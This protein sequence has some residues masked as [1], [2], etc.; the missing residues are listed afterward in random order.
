METITII[1]DELNELYDDYDENNFSELQIDE[2]F[3]RQLQLDDFY[4]YFD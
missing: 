3:H 1:V 4:N 2:D